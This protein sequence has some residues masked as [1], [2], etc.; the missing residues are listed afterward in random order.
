MCLCD[1]ALAD[2]FRNGSYQ[3]RGGRNAVLET[4]VKSG[5]QVSQ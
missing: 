3:P 1:I 2:T 5:S 4:G